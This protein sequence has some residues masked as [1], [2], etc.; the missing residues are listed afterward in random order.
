MIFEEW[1][2]IDFFNIKQ[3]TYLIS[4]FGKV[5]SKA[6]NGYLSPAI[7][8]GYYTVQL[9]MQDGTRK[10]FYIHRLVA[11]AFI[12]NP[13]PDILTDVNHKNLC[14][15]DDFTENLEWVTKQENNYHENINR[16]HNTEQ[17]S[18]KGA[19][20]NG[21]F[22]YGENNGMSKWKEKEVRIMLLA[23]ENG[24][25]YAEALLLA[26]KDVTSNNISN[27]SHIARGHRW[28]HLSKEYNIPKKIPH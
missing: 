5:F 19:W 20:G 14:R 8:N 16:G 1:K 15:S 24:S 18:G 11:K 7:T 12:Y 3:N 4:N 22:T 21:E 13:E 10:S 27:L 2:E 23:L 28:K 25:S 17:V 9:C 6:K 26:G